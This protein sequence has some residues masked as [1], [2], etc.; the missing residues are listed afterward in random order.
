[1]IEEIKSPDWFSEVRE[2]KKGFFSE[3]NLLLRALDRAFNPENLPISEQ[4]YGVRNFFPELSSV[5]DVILRVLGILELII[6]ESKKNAFWFQKFAE[7]K[8][9]SDRK[10]DLLR[11]SLYRQ[12]TPE[13]S[14]FLLYD[15]F[16]N[17]KVIIND[18]L[19]GSAVSYTG[20]KN[21]GDIL[22]REI[23]ENRIFD[24]FKKGVDHE[25]DSIDN[26]RIKEVVKSLRDSSYKR[27]ISGVFIYLFRFLRYLGHIDLSSDRTVSLNCAYLILVLLRSEIRS[28]V[29]YLDDMMKDMDDKELRDVLQSIAFQFSMESK[30]VYVQELRDVL[31][32]T[33][34]AQVRGRMENC[35][36]IFRNLTEQCIVQLAQ[37]FSP[38]IMGPE[39]F[40]SF[41]TRVE[42]SLR[43]R[44]DVYILCRFFE[45]FEGSMGDSGKSKKVFESLKDYMLYFE[46]LS[47]RLLRYDDYE[48]FQRFFSEFMSLGPDMLD[49]HGAHK[50]FEKAHKFRV[51]LETTLRL[52][53]QRAELRDKPIDEDRAQ[54]VLHQ[55]LPD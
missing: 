46:S 24:P 5:R 40:P 54:K 23:R 9:L 34:S 28:F 45:V 48:E 53:S 7:Q 47:F 21:F 22:G 27:E 43:L 11:E 52:I 4:S 49:S 35:H 15:S 31:L 51:Y 19:K 39:I 17:L 6:P 55:Y 44:D 33:S 20:Y 36:G 32:R 10:R 30:R 2:K 12:D 16:I 29:S 41:E 14:L 25:F 26:A 18:L 42:Q 8:F 38:D 50:V 1:M 3:I 37:H 13:K